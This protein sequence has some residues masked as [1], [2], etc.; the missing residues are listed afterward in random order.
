LPV[1]TRKERTTVRSN[2]AIF[3]IDRAG[4]SLLLEVLNA[5]LKDHLILVAFNVLADEAALTL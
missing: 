3:K 4:V 1:I 2:K 5:V